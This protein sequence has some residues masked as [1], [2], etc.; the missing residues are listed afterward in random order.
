MAAGL[1]GPL[2]G[3]DAFGRTM[4]DVR[5]R[6]N[7]GAILT[8]VS[9]MLIAALTMSEFADYLRVRNEPWL[10]VDYSRQEKL[11]VNLNIT[12]PRVPCYLLSLDVLDISGEINVDVRHDVT[13]TR[14]DRDGSIISI[15]AKEL[16]T[17]AARIAALRPK[18]YCGSC[19]GAQV[20]ESGC[21]NTCDDVR[22]AYAESRWSFNS[23]ESIEQ[24]VQEHWKENVEAE[25]HEGC[26]IAGV[27]HVN[28]VV[29]NLHLS[30]GRAFQS[31]TLFSNE[32]V[33]YMSGSGDEYHHFG[34]IIH[35]LSFGTDGEFPHDAPART[36]A[37]KDQLN[38]KD[39]LKGRVTHQK[40]SQF[41]Y[42]YFIKA[43]PTEVQLLHGARFRTYQYSVTSNE[44]DLAPNDPTKEHNPMPEDPN[45]KHTVQGLPG[46]FINYEISP[47]RVIQRQVR[48]SFTHFLTN[49]CAIVGGILT[50][51][52]LVDAAIYRSRK[53][54]TSDSYD[55][56]DVLDGY[57][58]SAKML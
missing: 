26:N 31:N 45:V 10:E 28:K 52:G 49:T 29:G 2:R 38:I 7:V 25:N 51:A 22:E 13:R 50:I 39:P 6:T 3:F 35:E 57:G 41:M 58:A 4:D 15:G 32:L 19:Y 40:A 47:L 56:D 44:R 20:P 30:P 18:G 36:V 46:V 8:F 55:D 11:E 1:L 21:C 12:F 9:A 42:Q 24:C 23:P 16:E 14:L 33:P 37:V 5:I 54:L 53:T 43:V 17:E 34:H 48:K 27:L